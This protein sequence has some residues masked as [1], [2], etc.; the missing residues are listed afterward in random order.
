MAKK[1]KYYVVWQGNNPGVYDNWT[2]CKL[3]IQ[4]YPGAKY[5][6]FTSRE[7]AVEAFRGSFDEHISARSPGKAKPKPAASEEARKEIVWDSIS[8]DAA[9]S[10]NPGVMEYQGVDTR[11]GAQIFHKKFS[12]GTNNIGEFLAIVHALALFKQQGK[13][14]PIYTD[15]K[16]AMSWVRRKKANTQLKRTA[17]AKLIWELIARA[18]AWLKN[19]TWDNPILKW[20]TER[21]GEIP[22]DFGRK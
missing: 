16:T 20:D 6:A 2:D 12:I 19:N 9:C 17:Q 1:K 5:K 11:T 21:W 10:G 18:E 4:G 8:V 3:Q 22:A 7:E 15:S 14:T 13:S